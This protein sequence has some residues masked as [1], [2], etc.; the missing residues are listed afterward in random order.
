VVTISFTSRKALSAIELSIVKELQPVVSLSPAFIASVSPNTPVQVQITLHGL[1]PA[2]RTLTGTIHLRRAGTNL[3]EARSLPIEI[4]IAGDS[5]PPDPG[6]AGQLTL[7]GVD[8]DAD[9]LRD[10][11][12]RHI[13]LSYDDPATRSALTVIAKSFQSALLGAADK[14]A[15]LNE[16]GRLQ[17]G[18]ECLYSFRSDAK[19][20]KN[21]LMARVLNTRE[22]SLAYLQFNHQLEG[23]IFRATPRALRGQVCSIGGVQ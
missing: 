16:A 17:R 15:S 22:R 2:N 18:I 4:V 1:P 11:L 20:T 12:Q 8:S 9:G 14:S 21:I 5:L 13:L 7:E 23:E 19:T 10:D 3:S 6:S